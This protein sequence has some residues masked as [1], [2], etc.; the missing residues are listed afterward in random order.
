MAAFIVL[1]WVGSGSLF[2]GGVCWIEMCQLNLLLYALAAVL[3]NCW[4]LW[5]Q[6]YNA[7]ALLSFAGIMGFVAASMLDA[8][9]LL[10]ADAV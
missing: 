9:S 2:C 7:V 8:G 3:C 1:V 4:S 5:S 6:V 10:N